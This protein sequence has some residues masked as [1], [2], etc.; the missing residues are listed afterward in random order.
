MSCTLISIPEFGTAHDSGAIRMGHST[1]LAGAW[2]AT[3]AATPGG[4]APGLLRSLCTTPG[5][6]FTHRGIAGE[7]PDPA[8]WHGRVKQRARARHRPPGTRHPE[9][10][11]LWGPD[12]PG[13]VSS[14][15]SADGCGRCRNWPTGRLLGRLGGHPLHAPGGHLV[16]LTRHPDGGV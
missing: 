7:T 13:R 11:H 12:L 10:A 9:S 8:T 6:A 5:T 14:G 3:P 4:G 15:H 1:D 16:V 2:L